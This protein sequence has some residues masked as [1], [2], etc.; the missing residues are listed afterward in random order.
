MPP[1]NKND[2][3]INIA[4]GKMAGDDDVF[5]KFEGYK[6]TIN[7]NGS[8]VHTERNQWQWRTL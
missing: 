1:K 4:D 8:G 3:R 2:F 5:P 6:T 7:A